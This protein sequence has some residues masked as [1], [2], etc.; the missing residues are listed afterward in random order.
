MLFFRSC[1]LLLSLALVGGCGFRPLYGGGKSGGVS[2]NLASIQI[3]PIGE[4]T[5]QLLHNHLLDLL[6]PRGRPKAPRFQLRVSLTESIGT[7]AVEK[8]AFATRA[9][10]Y[11]S[12]KF[13]L[14]AIHKGKVDT[15]KP[16]FAAETH[17]ISS[18]NIMDSEFATL[19]TEKDARTRA[20]RQIA[21]DIHTR[22]SLFFFQSQA[23]AQK[24]G[25]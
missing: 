23:A 7:L 5:G 15:S 17:T 12:A 16:F 3:Q 8:S 4:R 20:A 13:Q 11:L 18:F 2:P 19:A 9:N 22:L 1:A 25:K 24:T 10:F 6:N 21:Y 14:H